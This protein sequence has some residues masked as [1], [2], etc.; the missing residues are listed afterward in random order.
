MCPLWPGNHE[1]I[2][3][4]GNWNAGYRTVRNGTMYSYPFEALQLSAPLSDK[5]LP[6]LDD[7]LVSMKLRPRDIRQGVSFIRFPLPPQHH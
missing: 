3:R 7:D 4:E 2:G 5:C 1:N 6:E